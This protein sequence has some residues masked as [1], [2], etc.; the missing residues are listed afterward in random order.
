MIVT[1]NRER[2]RSTRVDE[3][4]KETSKLQG[5]E[6]RRHHQ[7]DR[8]RERR[9]MKMEKAYQVTKHLNEMNSQAI[10]SFVQMM[11]PTM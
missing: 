5:V 2:E 6:G 8:E 9:R 11:L 7:I 4:M 10:V 3:E 1:T